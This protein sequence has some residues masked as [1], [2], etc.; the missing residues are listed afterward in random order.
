M[1]DDP[2]IPL[3]EPFPILYR[4]SETYGEVTLHAPDAPPSDW[5]CLP[6]LVS[7]THPRHEAWYVHPAHAAEAWRHVAL[8]GP[9]WEW[10]FENET[11]AGR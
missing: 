5:A 6:W 10:D 9:Y 11:G 1:T 3:F 8:I 2:E 4:R 7:V